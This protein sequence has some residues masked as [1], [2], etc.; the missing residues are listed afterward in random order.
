MRPYFAYGA[1][2]DVAQMAD[3]CPGARI[4]D[5][6]ILADHKII[7]GQAGFAN[8]VPAPGKAVIGM[9]WDITPDDEAALDHYEG[10]RSGVYRK[11]EIDVTTTGGKNVRALYYHAAD[12]T[13]GTP[14]PGYLEPVVAA[15]RHHGL[16]AD[17]I[18]EL[19][20]WF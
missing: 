13:P 10:I 3:R 2:M 18:A 8:A 7:I 15:A 4:V 6:A 9:L 19:E 5:G 17:Y 1:N 11:D 14:A 12:P 20:G 16:P